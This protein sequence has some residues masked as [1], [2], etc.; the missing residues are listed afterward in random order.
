MKVLN[1][2]YIIPVLFYIPLN[3]LLQIFNVSE[4]TIKPMLV[5]STVLITLFI[6]N[7]LRKIEH[8]KEEIKQKGELENEEI[9]CSYLVSLIKEAFKKSS[10]SNKLAREHIND[11]IEN[12]E[13]AAFQIMEYAR[14]ISEATDNLTNEVDVIKKEGEKFSE[15]THQNIQENEQVLKRLQNYIGTNKIEMQEDMEIVKIL[16]ENVK[17]LTSLVELIKNVADQTNLLALNASI[18]AA[19]AGQYGRGFSVVAD[20]VRKLS[21]KSNKAADEIEKAVK[22]MALN[23]QSKLSWKTDEQLVKQKEEFLSKIETQLSAIGDSYRLLDH[24]NREIISRVV[25]STEMV[26]NKVLELLA[27][28]QFQDITRQQMEKIIEIN[29]KI[30]ELYRDLEAENME[31][32]INKLRIIADYDINQLRKIYIM[33]KQ[34]DTHDAY[35]GIKTKKTSSSSEENNIVF[36]D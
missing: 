3:Y 1:L 26:S 2:L 8:R 6:V 15:E 21:E 36:F 10:D 14:G 29:E 24:M 25:N 17:E 16:Q 34:R 33:Q 12:T 27:N 31:Q 19:R 22:L 18:E 35:M 20:E 23:I 11:V 28:I 7:I 32:L 13:K 5:I 4:S 30:E 9:S